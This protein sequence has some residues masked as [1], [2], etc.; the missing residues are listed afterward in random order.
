MSKGDFIKTY[1]KMSGTKIS[2]KEEVENT[3]KYKVEF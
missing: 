1:K 3:K 2:S